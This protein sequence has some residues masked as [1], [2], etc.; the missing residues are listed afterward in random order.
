M[1][2]FRRALLICGLLMAPG[3]SFAEVAPSS[4]AAD[5]T[6]TKSQS[7][8][9]IN[10][11]LTIAVGATL[12]IESGITLTLADKVSIRVQ[13]GL[14]ARGSESDPIRV[15]GGQNDSGQARWGSITFKEG[16]TDASFSQL[17]D[18]ENGSI[19]EWVIFD[20]GTQ[21]LRLEGTSPYVHRCTFQNN[22]SGEAGGP[23][24]TATKGSRARIRNNTFAD[25][26]ADGFSAWGGAVLVESS[27]VILQ[28]N[29]FERNKSYYGGGLTT[30]IAAGPIVGNTFN[31]NDGQWEGGGL[32][33][34]TTCSAFLNNTVTNNHSAADGGGVH[35]C[36]DCFPHA[37]PTVMDNVISNNKNDIVGAAGIGAAHIRFFRDNDIFDNER[38]NKSSNFAW[39]NEHFDVYPSWSVNPDIANNWWGTTDSATVAKSINDGEDDATYGKAV[40]EPV[41]TGPV[42]KPRTRVMITTRKI[43]YNLDQEEMP[44]F[45]TIYN[46]GAAREVELFVYLQYGAIGPLPYRGTISFPNAEKTASGFKLKLPENSVFFD[47]LIKP[48]YE[49]QKALPEGRWYAVLVDSSTGERIGETNFAR[50]LMGGG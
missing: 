36:V 1:M 39:F 7:P 27:D 40:F 21:A 43:R 17:D 47:T 48:N 9:L 35:V 25:N 15:E 50:F 49:E 4:I 13:G 34:V 11:T 44:V 8:I 30:N 23:A 41:A 10:E 33:M 20:H 29:T 18:Y 26:Y 19:V 5:T 6:W 32:S 22:Y 45:L 37:N 3:F 24:I 31:D 28:D 16:S 46:P 42:A 14:K 2:M 38:F 12:T